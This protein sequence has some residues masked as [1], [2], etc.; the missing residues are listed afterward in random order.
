MRKLLVAVVALQ[1][2]VGL[3]A[4][5]TVSPPRAGA[6]V[7]GVGP[8]ERTT[9]AEPAPVASLPPGETD[10]ADAA[11]ATVPLF[12][13]ADAPEPF[14]TLTNPTWEGVPLVLHVLEDRGPWLLTRINTRPNGSTAWVRR[15]DVKLRRMPNRILIELG[16]RRLTVLHGNDV[17][18]QHRVGI[19]TART[20]TPLGEFYVD[21]TVNLPKANGPYGAGQL[22]VS[23]FS[24]VYKTF[25]GG[26]GQIAIH[27]T[28]NPSSIGGTVSNGCI[29]MLNAAWIQVASLASNGTP[30]S[31]QA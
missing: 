1:L 9:T 24:E 25:G 15:A 19:G 31:I 5:L 13:A 26:I 10:A 21:A 7:V 29:R 23:G 14:K 30:V 18:A 28:N 27:G 20:P 16:E 6:D 2:V 8:I 22:S 11:G 4:A 3:I 12:K 17:L